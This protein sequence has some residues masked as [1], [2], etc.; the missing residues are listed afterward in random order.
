[1]KRFALIVFFLLLPSSVFA[2]QNEPDGFRGIK[3]G[4]DLSTL[5]DMSKFA[6]DIKDGL[7]YERK[8]DTLTVGDATLTGI[9]YG[10]YDGKFFSVMMTFNNS[11][12]FSKI[13]ETLFQ[14]YG[15][16]EK[17]NP[18]IDKYKWSGVDVVIG[19]DYSSINEEGKVVY[20]YLPTVHKR[21]S[22]M[23][24]RAKK[25]GKDL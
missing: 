11:S 19:L 10:F 21:E 3:W 17:L 9:Y 1:M 14:K 7:L 16:I 20:F 15:D 8:N 12:N 22:D 25:A 6:G 5:S 4:T 24:E 18:Y 23:K 13:K 2:F